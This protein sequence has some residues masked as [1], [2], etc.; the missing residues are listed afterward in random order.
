[1]TQEEKD[2]FAKSAFSE[3]LE[4]TSPGI[5]QCGDYIVWDGPGVRESD[6]TVYYKVTILRWQGETSI[7]T[8]SSNQAMREWMA[9]HQKYLKGKLIWYCKALW[10]LF[11]EGLLDSDDFDRIEGQE[12]EDE[13][14]PWEREERQQQYAEAVELKHR[15]E[16]K[17]GWDCS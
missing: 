11:D 14:E 1:M 17:Y 12:D 8:W 7:S 2:K 9:A 6:Y 16:Q 4:N 5:Y 15:C 10:S 3:W 13:L